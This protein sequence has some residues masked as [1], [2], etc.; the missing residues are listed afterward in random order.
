MLE[1]MLISFMASE[2]MFD[3][4]PA[5]SSGT[6]WNGNGINIDGDGRGW[7]RSCAGT[8]RDGSESGWGWVGMETKSVGMGVISVAV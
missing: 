6:G 7:N 8:G 5:V 2:F 3:L 4:L 1:F